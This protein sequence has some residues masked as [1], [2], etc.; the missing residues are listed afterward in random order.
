MT[1]TVAES[2]ESS[3]LST[4]TLSGKETDTLN[5]VAAWRVARP[6]P[7]LASGWKGRV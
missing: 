6:R 5:S 4:G 3:S 7:G 2:L 1:P